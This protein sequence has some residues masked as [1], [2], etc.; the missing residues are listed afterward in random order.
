MTWFNRLLVVT[1]IVLSALGIY[2]CAQ[3]TA[4]HVTKNVNSSW[5]G[6]LCGKG[7][8]DC[9]KV[10]NSRWAVFPP[11]PH[12]APPNSLVGG[13]WRQEALD[14]ASG[15]TVAIPVSYLGLLYF[16]LLTTWFLGV[17]RPNEHGRLW[18]LLPCLL[19][20]LGCIGSAGFMMLMARTVKAWCPGCM[21]VHGINF[22]LLIILLL[23]W[24]RR[25]RAKPATLNTK[26]DAML[27]GHPSVIHPT[28]RLALVTLGMGISLWLACVAAT[29]AQLQV[30]KAR[31]LNAI[32][33]E[34]R[35]NPG[36]LAAMYWDQDKK[37]I[38]PRSVD[39]AF[40]GQEDPPAVLVVFSDMEC[41]ECRKF[42]AFLGEKVKP[43]FDDRFRVV[44]KHYPLS[45][46]C[47]P[48]FEV[49]MHTYSC[50][51]AFALEA[52]R[53]QGGDPLFLR[54]RDEI[55]ARSEEMWSLDYGAL[56]ALLGMD[57]ERFMTDMQGDAVR[58]RVAQDIDLG[59]QLGVTQTPTLFLNGRSVPLL[60]R[61]KE[62][63]WI[64]L[65]TKL[66][67]SG[68]PES[69]AATASSLPAEGHP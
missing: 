25:R 21:M 2:L 3:L 59:H 66:L 46:Q 47:N 16:V 12:K 38:D 42:E 4:Q 14:D 51:A 36:L 17:G 43:L 49:N 53:L 67:D 18:H 5:L 32:L 24:P 20:F 11:R 1:A 30:T 63:F 41:S 7:S 52:A 60:C 62:D 31:V 65:L 57:V 23:M 6:S 55:L 56:A 61:N 13:A 50:A 39:P 69:S 64:P 26:G 8:M 58:S 37:P 68:T 27:S 19:V 40:D 45:N 48:Y 44:F 34:T 15:I 9:D 35:A 29:A 28:P 22:A 10:L 54:M 33:D